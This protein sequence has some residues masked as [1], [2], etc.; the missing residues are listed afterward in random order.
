MVL[1]LTTRVVHHHQLAVAVHDH[2]TA[3]LALGEVGVVEAHDALRLHLERTLLDLAARRRAA[4]VEGPHREL[5]AGLT[6]RLSG[7]DAD[8]FTDVHLVPAREV[9]PVAHAAHAALGLAGEHRP[10][11]D[12]FDAR[13]LDLAR[14]G[15]VEQ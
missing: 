8:R 5:S 9:A 1:A 7:D 2:D 13:F 15:L 11:H 14:Q 10:N 3:V 12:L 6:D 4:D